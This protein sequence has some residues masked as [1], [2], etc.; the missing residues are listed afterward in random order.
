MNEKE[1][2][3]TY[4]GAEEL[5]DQLGSERIDMMR[6]MMDVEYK[7]GEEEDG[8]ATRT[9]RRIPTL[10]PYRDPDPDNPDYKTPLSPGEE[11]QFQAWVRT[12]TVPF[13]DSATSDYD[14]RGFWKAA[15]EGDPNAN[16]AVSK[17]DNRI[18]FP[19]TFKTPYHRTFSNESQ[20]A[21]SDAP[22]WVGDRL[23]DKNGNVVADETPGAAQP[24]PGTLSA[25]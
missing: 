8:S 9:E 10:S 18:H 17:F 1:H 6:S 14:M 16:T 19:D 5:M 4:P 12:N 25:S 3:P 2:E 15:Q 20:Y 21:T 13:D 11:K 7:P 24:A 22:H 23:I